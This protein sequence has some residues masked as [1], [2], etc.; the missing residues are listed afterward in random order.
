MTMTSL[1]TS[2]VTTQCLL[3]SRRVNVVQSPVLYTFYQHHPMA[4]TLDT[5]ATTIMIRASTARLYNLH[6]KPASPIARQADG[7]TP[8]DV[9]GEVHCNVTRGHLSFQLDVKQLDVDVLVGN[10]FLVRSDIAVRP[11]K[12]QI[13]IGDADIVYCGTDCGKTS[14]LSVRRMKAFL[15]RSPRKTV[16][17]PGD[18][19]ELHTPHDVNSDTMWTLEPRMDSRSNIQFAAVLV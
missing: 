17:F 9:I 12:K 8:L 18:Y 1:R 13:I 11:Y 15:L 6:I 3:S 19:L 10:S 5:S 14:L 2:L 4:L 16:V 7:L